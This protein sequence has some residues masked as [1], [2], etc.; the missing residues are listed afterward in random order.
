[1]ICSLIP[2]HISSVRS[3]VNAFLD[4]SPFQ[5]RGKGEGGTP[6]TSRRLSTSVRRKDIWDRLG[7]FRQLQLVN[8]YL[9]N[10]GPITTHA[11]YPNDPR[12]QVAER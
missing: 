2:I 1:M 5:S 8:S 7:N 3:D 6:E 10:H 12:N 4:P 11:S 9:G